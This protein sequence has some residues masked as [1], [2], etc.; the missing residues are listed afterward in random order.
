MPSSPAT[1]QFVIF[2]DSLTEWSFSEETQGF[3]LFLSQLYQHK[4][5]I[6]VLFGASIVEWSF[7]EETQGFGWFLERKYANKAKIVNEGTYCGTVP[8]HT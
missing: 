1:P 7:R 4:V 8:F 3:G 5:D 6:I 2:G